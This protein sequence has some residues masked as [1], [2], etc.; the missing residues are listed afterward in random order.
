[1]EG[2][3]LSVY[4]VEIGVT[5]LVIIGRTIRGWEAYYLDGFCPD[6]SGRPERFRVE[7][8]PNRGASS[9]GRRTDSEKIYWPSVFFLSSQLDPDTLLTAF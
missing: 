6:I 5:R 7:F 4:F 2:Q 8:C 3:S 9:C 1:M